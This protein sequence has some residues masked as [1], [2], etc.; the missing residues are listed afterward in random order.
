[1]RLV[2][3]YVGTQVGTGIKYAGY[4]R[5]GCCTR[6]CLFCQRKRAQTVKEEALEREE[7]LLNASF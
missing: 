5:H 1:M 4:P 7:Y 3:Y 6:A 2:E